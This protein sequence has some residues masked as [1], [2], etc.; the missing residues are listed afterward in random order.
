VFCGFSA[1]AGEGESSKNKG[2][3]R[4]A[5]VPPAFFP[6]VSHAGETPALRGARRYG[7]TMGPGLQVG[8]EDFDHRLIPAGVSRR[9]EFGVVQPLHQ[10]LVYTTTRRR[11]R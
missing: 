5:G 8:E 4:S 10:A 3:R 6:A 9:I 1:G 7:A 2:L 11:S